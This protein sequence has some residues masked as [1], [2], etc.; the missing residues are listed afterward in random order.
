MMSSCYQI[1]SKLKKRNSAG[2]LT[3]RHGAGADVRCHAA[4]AG[5]GQVVAG[6]DLDL[7]AGEVAQVGNDG[8][9]LGVDRDHGLCALKGFLILVVRDT[10]AVRWAGGSGEEGVCSVGDTHHRAPLSRTS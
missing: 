2:A 4:A 6:V 10:G 3:F 9:L 8:G 5:F 1:R 7:V